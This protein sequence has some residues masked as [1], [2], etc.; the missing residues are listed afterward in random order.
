V[1]PQTH[2]PVISILDSAFSFIFS[3]H[4]YQAFVDD[5]KAI[6]GKD[7]KASDSG[8]THAVTQARTNLK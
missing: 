6:D 1:P 7:T 3:C 4:S 8:R 5:F 2:P